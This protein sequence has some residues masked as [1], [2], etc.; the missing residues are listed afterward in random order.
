MS[1]FMT[2]L[3]GPLDKKYCIYFYFLSI[4][5]YV[6]FV[7]SGISLIA[8]FFKKF[9]KTVLFNNAFVLINLL[10]AYFVNRLFYTICVSSLR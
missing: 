4:I 6:F 10:I 8:L 7:V 2:T 1:D 5:L 3:F 9:D